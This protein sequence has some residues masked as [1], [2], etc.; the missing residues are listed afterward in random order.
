MKK[1]DISKLRNRSV[2]DFPYKKLAAGLGVVMLIVG[3]WLLMLAPR[4]SEANTAAAAR[5]HKED[6]ERQVNTPSGEPRD[7][8]D[9]STQR[10]TTLAEAAAVANGNSRRTDKPAAQVSGDTHTHHNHG[11]VYGD[12]KK[13]G[14]NAAGCYFDYG[15]P[16]EQCLSAATAGAD[17]VLTCA[18]VRV[19][20]ASGIKVSGTDRFHL[21][22]N[23]DR[24]AC[25]AGE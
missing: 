6:L 2:K 22:H 5:A 19:K 14:I 10:Q 7:G 18:E 8:R 15:I 16:G 25:G 12:P 24:T 21:D 11:D 3:V 23:G 9:P 1:I 20:F 17:G 13:T 4:I